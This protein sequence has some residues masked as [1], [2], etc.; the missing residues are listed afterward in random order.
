MKN[1]LIK[2]LFL[3][4]VVA[5]SLTSC[6]DYLDINSDPNQSTSSRDDLQ[7]S[8]AQL[9]VSVA[10]GDRIT[11]TTQ[12]W[13]QYWTG[14]P[15]VSLGEQDQHLLSSSEC[16]QL[17]NNMYRGM[18]NLKFILDNSKESNYIGIAKVIMAYNFGV[19]ADLFGNIP[20][21]EAL[22]GDI[23]D[24][25]VFAPKYDDAASVVYPEI[26]KLLKEAIPLLGDTHSKHPGADDL[27]YG[28]DM[29]KWI[30]F[31][32]SLLLKTY[33]RQGD[34]GKDKLATFFSGND[35]FI[36]TNSEMAAVAFPG[37]STANNPFWTEAK[38]SALGNYL[39]ATTTSIDYLAGTQDPRIDYFY[40]KAGNGLH[41]GLKYG[42]I[43]NQPPT[44]DFSKPH[45]AKLADGGIIFSPTA[46]VILMSA[47]EVNLLLA[48]A[49][50]RAWISGDAKALYD[51]GVKENFSYLGV[52]A[53]D[54]DT[55]L[56]GKG[57]LDQANAIKSIALQ[58]WVCMTGLQSVES[59]IETRRFDN[60]G[61]PIFSSQGGIFITP[62]KNGLGGNT[63]P[64]ILPYPES[65]E[66]LNKSFP[67]QHSIT[68]KVFWDK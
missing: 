44:A 53:L 5:A 11:Y 39:V 4:F 28:G 59:W 52:P 68:S 43:E 62:T 17:F 16:N 54:A 36:L 24:G 22:R 15:G 12:R 55:Y 6:D 14:G 9:Y 25:S 29:A 48:E 40:N 10:M 57:A 20:V 50:S 26:E 64:S 19:C 46:P 21:L 58:K 49:V 30:K 63:F 47:W 51:A 3:M 2:Y 45:G 18:S 65:E 41:V 33:I 61:S 32:N 38:S 37:G 27:I 66:S 31:A 34:S 35:Q 23:N 67:G 8:S 60:S 1:K 13:A 56:A 42:D 7:L